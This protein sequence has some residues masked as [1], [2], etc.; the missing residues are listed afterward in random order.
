MTRAAGDLGQAAGGDATTD[1]A[2]DAAAVPY[3]GIPALLLEVVD[4]PDPVELGTNTVYT[5]TV[6]NQGSKEGSDI[7][8]TTILPSQMSYVSSGG[9]TSGRVTGS[10]ITFGALPSLAPGAS[11]TWLVTARADSEGSVRTRFTLDS[12]YLA[13]NLVEETESTNLY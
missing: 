9:P 5:I 2:S 13:G 1:A 11:A 7:V 10:T 6:T 4:G 8:V 12:D 3:E